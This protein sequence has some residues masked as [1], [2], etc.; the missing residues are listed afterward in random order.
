MA[1]EMAQQLIRI[2]QSVSLILLDTRAPIQGT[3]HFKTKHSCSP[4]I[5]LL[6]T[7][8][9]S[10]MK[11]FSLDLKNLFPYLLHKTRRVI[12]LLIYRNERSLREAVTRGAIVAE[13]YCAAISSYRPQAYLGKVVCIVSEGRDRHDP[14]LGW[15]ELVA[16][17]VEVH[18]VHGNHSSYIREFV[19]H[20]GSQLAKCLQAASDTNP[21][22]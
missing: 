17:G 3:Y 6:R 16:G 9:N 21:G 14:T 13:S 1:F 12:K 4:R 19:Q 20:T 7:T 22:Q 15:K 8:I 5:S 18:I 2:G 11:I 10:L